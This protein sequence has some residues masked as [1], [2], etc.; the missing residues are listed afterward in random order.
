MIAL[1]KSRR[2]TATSEDVVL[3]RLYPP[4]KKGPMS[5]LGQKQTFA[6]QNA[7]SAS[8]PKATAKA[9]FRKR[10][11]LLYPQ[12]RTCAVQTQMSAKGQ[13]GTFHPVFSKHAVSTKRHLDLR[14]AGADRRIIK[15]RLIQQEAAPWQLHARI[16]IRRTPRT[17]LLA[18]AS[19]TQWRRLG[20]HHHAVRCPRAMDCAERRRLD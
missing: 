16:G 8:P 17:L 2:L 11:C 1:T 13:K 5:A 3:Y 15:I 12:K 20:L 14:H 7:M 6:L 10:S 4:P 18:S 9:D 19:R